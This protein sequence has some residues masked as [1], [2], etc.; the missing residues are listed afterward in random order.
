M[1]SKISTA[2]DEKPG[3]T[4]R[5]WQSLRNLPWSLPPEKKKAVRE[6]FSIWFRFCSC[7]TLSRTPNSSDPL[8]FIAQHIILKFHHGKKQLQYPYPSNLFGYGILHALPN[9][10]QNASGQ[11]LQTGLMSM[12]SNELRQQAPNIAPQQHWDATKRREKSPL[13]RPAEDPGEAEV[14]QCRE[15]PGRMTRTGRATRPAA[16]ASA[17]PAP[18]CVVPAP[19][20]AAA[21]NQQRSAGSGE[22]RAGQVPLSRG[23]K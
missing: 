18:R 19:G 7:Q 10:V 1:P 12:N 2:G 13:R 16:A 21:G 17:I 20:G 11:L 14:P 9:S 6:V 23:S 5:V 22:T 3:I 15:A 8:L 4:S